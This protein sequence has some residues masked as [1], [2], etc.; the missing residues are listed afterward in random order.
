M[1]AMDVARGCWKP[2]STAAASALATGCGPAGGEID[3]ASSQSSNRGHDV[4][5]LM[6]TVVVDGW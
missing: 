5:I 4:S 1:V 3:A 6:V 2:V